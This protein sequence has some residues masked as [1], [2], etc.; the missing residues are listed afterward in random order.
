MTLQNL[1]EILEVK[2]KE[3]LAYTGILA[4]KLDNDE[5]K[6]EELQSA[7]DYLCK[8]MASNFIEKHKEY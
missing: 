1:I 6:I 7:V 5:I 2:E 8:N 4:R 3:A